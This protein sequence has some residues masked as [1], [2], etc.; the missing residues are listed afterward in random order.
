MLYRMHYDSPL[1]GIL[2]L[3]SENA[4]MD[5][6]CPDSMRITHCWNR[7]NSGKMRRFFGRGARG[8]IVISVGGVPRPRKSRW[9]PGAAS[10][11]A[12]SGRGYAASLTENWKPTGRLPGK[13]Q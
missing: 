6:G 9:T 1:G 7:Q 4:L 3:A 10:S 11:G 2:L 12:G 5:C 13:W 8:W